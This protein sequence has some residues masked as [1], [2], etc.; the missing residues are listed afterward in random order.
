MDSD[1]LYCLLGTV[2]FFANLSWIGHLLAIFALRFRDVEQI[3]STIIPLLF[4]LTPVLFRKNAFESESIL[5]LLNMNPFTL[6]IEIARSPL[7][8]DEIAL[9]HY[10]IAFAM[11]IAGWLTTLL[12]EK[13]VG[14]KLVFWI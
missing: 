7:I 5:L 9:S 1:L 12:I 10:L 4:F 14:S 8:G 2:L 6:F 11:A 13:K 3:V